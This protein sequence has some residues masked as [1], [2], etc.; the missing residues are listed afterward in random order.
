[1]LIYSQIQE[2]EAPVQSAKQGRKTPV[3]WDGTIS[4]KVIS[5]F[6]DRNEERQAMHNSALSIGE[7]KPE[8]QW[9]FQYGL[10]YLPKPDDNDAYRTVRV[11]GLP[12]DITMDKV[13]AEVCCG[14]VY[15]IDLL[16]TFGIT[17]YHTARV[18]F[19]HQ[20]SAAAFCKHAKKKGLF[21]EGVR[22]RATLEKTATYPISQYMRDA[23]DNDCCTRCLRVLHGN[24]HLLVYTRSVIERSI[25][26]YTTEAL[27]LEGEVIHIRF[28]SMKAAAFAFHK[29]TNDSALAACILKYGKDPCDRVP[30]SKSD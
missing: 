20:K 7:G 23:I 30:G 12:R 22:I 26:K 16:N 13:F 15:S 14:E 28:H 17:G 21:I 1:M 18:I 4:W 25:L 8:Q 10:R 3:P 2:P 11:E 27:D 24:S 29:F 6:K 9:L 19:L 5:I